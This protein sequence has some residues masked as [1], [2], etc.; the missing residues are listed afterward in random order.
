MTK[1]MICVNFNYL[2]INVKDGSVPPVH[3]MGCLTWTWCSS[4]RPGRIDELLPRSGPPQSRRHLRARGTFLATCSLF[5]QQWRLF[6]YCKGSIDRCCRG[7]L[8]GHM[9]GWHRLHPTVFG[10][11][12]ISD[13]LLL[14]CWFQ[15]L[16]CMLLV[17][18]THNQC[19]KP[20]PWLQPGTHR[21]R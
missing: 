19:R 7:T 21:D 20:L 16:D 8:L 15:D 6:H 14:E 11:L 4:P 5:H 3:L 10:R 1:L 17:H 13:S 12:G 9:W 2:N 18:C